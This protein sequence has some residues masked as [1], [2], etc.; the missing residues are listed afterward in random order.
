ASCGSLG[1]AK[2]DAEN[3]KKVVM[4]TEEFLPYPHNPSSIKQ[5]EV[6]YIVKVKRV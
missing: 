3:A 1:Y 2:I 4:L 5:D 6:D